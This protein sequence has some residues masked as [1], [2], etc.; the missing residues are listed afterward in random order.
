MTYEEAWGNLVKYPRSFR[1][2]LCPDGL[3]EL[4]DISCGDAWHLYDGDDNAGVSLILVRSDRGKDLLN[5]AATDGYVEIAQA[6]PVDVI[7]AQPL[8]ERR[9][10]VFGRMLVMKAF[11]IPVPEFINFPLREPGGRIRRA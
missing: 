9:S 5:R 6:Q 7:R 8:T 4:A 3:G 10:I 11:C 2:H 1:C